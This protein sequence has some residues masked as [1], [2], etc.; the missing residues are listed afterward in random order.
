MSRISKLMIGAGAVVALSVAGVAFAAWTGSGTG[1][2]RARATTAVVATINPVNGTADLFPG[3]TGGDLF[4][5]IT[6]PNPYAIT[7]TSMTPGA[8]TVDAG[9]PGCPAN[10]VTVAP[11]TG[12]NLASPPGPSA[13]L[14]I[15]DVVS[16]VTT[17]PD[18][19]QG[20]SFDVVLTLSGQQT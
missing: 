12:L 4:F 19:C 13:Q 14:S 15:A 9:H 5:T 2:G 7:F 6:N 10:S 18:A 11:A 1:S 8:V 17:A 16:M 20:A 3:F